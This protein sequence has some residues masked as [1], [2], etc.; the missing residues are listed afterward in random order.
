MLNMMKNIFSNYLNNSKYCFAHMGQ[1][2]N[3]PNLSTDML[4]LRSKEN[5][6]VHNFLQKKIITS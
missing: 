2:L 5:N 3:N 6:Q 4:L 1:S